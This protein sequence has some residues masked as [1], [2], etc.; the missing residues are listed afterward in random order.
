ML[1]LYNRGR[2]LQD[3]DIYPTLSPALRGAKDR[4]SSEA[5]TRISL[6]PS[7]ESRVEGPLPEL[8]MSSDAIMAGGLLEDHKDWKL[9]TFC[10]C[11]R[12]R[13]C[14]SVDFF[15]SERKEATTGTR[16]WH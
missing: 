1:N 2:Q 12:G 4:D 10:G 11:D 14:R 6:T 15:E 8:V 3:A 13:E 9:C 5:E 16:S 7:Q